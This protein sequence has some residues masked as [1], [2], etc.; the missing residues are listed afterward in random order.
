[1]RIKWILIME[2]GDYE[3]ENICIVSER[4]EEEREMQNNEKGL[5][6]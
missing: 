3:N 6:C 4:E 2:L 1:M 5:E